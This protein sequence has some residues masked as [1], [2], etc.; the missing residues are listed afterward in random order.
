VPT[1][2][3]PSSRRSRSQIEDDISNAILEADVRLVEEYQGEMI[4]YWRDESRSGSPP[5]VQSE[6]CSC[7]ACR[8]ERWLRERR[9]GGVPER[10]QSVR[11]AERRCEPIYVSADAAPAPEPEVVRTRPSRAERAFGER[12]VVLISLSGESVEFPF[13]LGRPLRAQLWRPATS[14][15]IVSW[16][17]AR[18]GFAMPTLLVQSTVRR[19]EIFPVGCGVGEQGARQVVVRSASGRFLEENEVEPALEAWRRGGGEAMPEIL[20]E[21]EFRVKPEVERPRNG[22]KKP[23]FRPFG[24]VWEAARGETD[25]VYL[26]LHQG[27]NGVTVR[28]VDWEGHIAGAGNLVYFAQDSGRLHLQ[29]CS[30]IESNLPV[31][32]VGGQIRIMGRDE[33]EDGDE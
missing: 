15:E 30:S 14:Q 17:G 27:E 16:I 5:W 2:I 29:L 13:L 9:R 4:E 31:E 3:Q 26:Q 28:L 7:G 11:P 6:T 18:G 32:L 10:D 22:R 12:L 23:S 24:G 20:R 25:A 1:G 8:A 19:E 21:F 33:E